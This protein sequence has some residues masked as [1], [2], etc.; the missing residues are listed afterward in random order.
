MLH[1]DYLMISNGGCDPF[2]YLQ[3]RGGLGYK[4]SHPY[5][6][7]LG[8]D[9]NFI[10]GC[11]IIGGG[12]EKKT[13]R[14]FYSPDE[15]IEKIVKPKELF[16]VLNLNINDIEE[17]DPANFLNINQFPVAQFELENHPNYENFK[18]AWE[19]EKQLPIEE[20][21]A[22]AEQKKEMYKDLMVRENEAILAKL[23]KE[24][25]LERYQGMKQEELKE[26][27]MHI[28][29]LYSNKAMLDKEGIKTDFSEDSELDRI[30]KRLKR[31]VHRNPYPILKKD[32]DE[33]KILKLSELI[34]DD[35][36][37]DFEDIVM[38][39]PKQDVIIPQS[40]KK[41]EQKQGEAKAV[42]HNLFYSDTP[43]AEYLRIMLK[44]VYPEIY[45]KFEKEIEEG[46]NISY[47][48]FNTG[49][50]TKDKND[51]T[52][53][54]GDVNA[55]IDGYTNFLI[56]GEKVL[57]ISNEA[58]NFGE[59]KYKINSK[60]SKTREPYLKKIE[61]LEDEIDE[62]K[63]TKAKILKQ[64]KLLKSSK[65]DKKLDKRYL[66]ILD[67]D[68][69]EKYDEL[70]IEKTK[71]IKDPDTKY[72][73]YLP[74]EIEEQNK[75]Y[76]EELRTRRL[77]NMK[78]IK[79]LKNEISLQEDE[80]IKNLMINKVKDLQDANKIIKQVRREQI[81]SR[82]LPMG[83][84]KLAFP[85]DPHDEEN[86]E[87][88]EYTNYA[89]KDWKKSNTHIKLKKEGEIEKLVNKQ[90]EEVIWSGQNQS[91]PHENSLMQYTLRTPKG[92]AVYPLSKEVKLGNFD[93]K[94]P[95]KNRLL[96]FPSYGD[97]A[98]TIDTITAQILPDEVVVLRK[99]E[100]SLK[101][102]KPKIN[103]SKKKDI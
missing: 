97:K 10:D 49:Y 82:A 68:I 37:R 80:K 101:K 73:H 52:I 70:K 24:G 79:T 88:P 87:K 100:K 64:Q 48:A 55:L 41:G 43:E 46:K 13:N 84:N 15:E 21:L 9:Y 2:H 102:E 67:D 5:M 29:E 75:E 91:N 39:L 78:K 51:N 50:N 85:E 77:L 32:I 99:E 72:Q 11:G 31:K 66:D 38:G 81:R 76:Y 83:I 44:Q 36:K 62:T 3:G 74:Y 54:K 18:M 1:L 19:D 26:I 34:T 56:D 47:V 58:K 7:G 69:D 60:N 65:R 4:P 6:H 14:Y 27:P 89:A 57:T 86:I 61:N 22:R 42:T 94:K 63:K 12:R 90:G 25:Q 71:Y 53:R 103:K 33:N 35:K 23:K 40:K 93:I 30:S 17:D 45:E 8:Y 92:I 95:L 98:N 16:R 59:G 28:K 20:R 96:A